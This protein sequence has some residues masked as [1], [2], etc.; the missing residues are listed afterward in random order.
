MSPK[1]Y[2]K[3]MLKLIAELSKLPSIGQKSAARLAY[4][5]I[6]SDRIDANHLAESIVDAKSSI[7]LCK[8]C[9]HLAEDDL[10]MICS[11]INRDDSL[12][13]VVEKPADVIALEVSGV[14]SGSYHVLH[15]LW[16]PLKGI[17][18]DKIR[19]KELFQRIKGSHDL[20][21]LLVAT[22]TTVEGD[23]TALYIS[24][25]LEDSSIKTSRIAQGLPKGGELEYADVI[26]IGHAI[27]G[28][29]LL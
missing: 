27:S 28:R 25:E 1:G 15:G 11:D 23:A 7:K 4:S 6:L 22:P 18:P 3:K 24:Q 17:S 26:T 21:E 19:L 2:P 10:C 13:C 16:S 9:F 12:I 14:F 20:S 8:N 29:K 5:L